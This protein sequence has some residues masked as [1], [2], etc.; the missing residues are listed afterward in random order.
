MV[1]APVILAAQQVMGR[2]CILLLITMSYDTT[3]S[4][5]LLP[6]YLSV[7]ATGRNSDLRLLRHVFIEN[8]SNLRP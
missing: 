3:L 2:A 5:C 4:P 1:V 7:L 6:I 8:P